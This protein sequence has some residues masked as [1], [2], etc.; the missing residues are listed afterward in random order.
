MKPY[1]RHLMFVSAFVLAGSTIPVALSPEPA[2][3]HG[4]SIDVKAGVPRGS[5]SLSAV[6]IKAL[7]LQTVLAD[8]R[9]ISRLLHTHGE[10]AP[11]S[12]K[13]ADVSLRISGNVQNVFVNVGDKVQ[14]GQK[15]ALVQSRVI[16]N[17]PP[18]VAVIA[19]MT[20]VIDAR[21]IIKGQSVEPNSS[22][23]HISDLTR[24]RVVAKVYEEDLGQLHLGQK[25]YVKLLAY[26]HELLTGVVSMIGPTLD[27]DTRTVEIW[28][29]L[30]N[31]QGLLKPNLFAKADIVLSQNDAALTVPN[32]AV[33]EANGEKFV[34]LKEGNKFYRVEVEIGATDDVYT[35][36]K[37]GIVP[38]DE[39]VTVGAREV[40]TLWLTGGKLEAEE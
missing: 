17:P 40:Y 23:F 12:D 26:P 36:I 32:A 34:F 37:S 13:Q 10:L 15:L 35:E 7:G 8:L 28:I 3:A 22:L 33:L 31:K 24:M 21:N 14:K 20:G 39:I 25:A 29:V 1:I 5:V 11:L 16:G 6:Q 30:N 18:S 9:P 4:A 19:P 27:Q 38:G 2:F